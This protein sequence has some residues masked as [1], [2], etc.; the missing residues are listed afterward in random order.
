MSCCT[1][2]FGL[3]GA[4]RFP[5]ILILALCWAAAP[6]TSAGQQTSTLRQTPAA[7]QNGQAKLIGAYDPTQKLRLAIV[8][9]PPHLS[10]EEQFLRELQD[11]HS[12]N[13]HKFLS[14]QEWNQRFAPSPEDEQAVVTWA[15]SQGLTITQRFPN[16]LVV[17]VEAPVAVIEKTFNVGINS[18]QVGERTC[19]SNDRD[20]AIPT[21]L[22]AT[23]QAVL[24]LNSIEVMRSAMGRRPGI[25]EPAWPD[26]APGPAYE[27]GPLLQGD[28][29]HSRIETLNAGD[30]RFGFSNPYGPADI[31]ASTAYDYAALQN[32]GHC[33][34]P[35]ANPGGSP[36]QSSVAIA[37]WGDF[38]D[39]DFHGFISTFPYLAYN[40]QRYYVNGHAPCCDAET[41]L[42]VEWSTAMANSFAWGGTTATI[43]VYIGLNGTDSTIID[44]L[45]QALSDGHARVLN[46]SWGG[47]EI[48]EI[49]ATS[50]ISMHNIF[51]QY[52]GEGWALSAASG[53]GGATTDC[54]DHLSVNYPA[55]DPNVTA[56]G[57][58]TLTTSSSGFMSEV[59][60]MG[61]A[62]GCAQNDGGGGGGCSTQFAA[63]AYQGSTAC[64]AGKRSVPDVALNADWDNEPQYLFY[65]GQLYAAGG[66]SISAPEFSG[67]L[68]QENAYLL[69]LQNIVGNTCG[70]S[71]N[72]ACSPMGNP[73]PFIYGEGL[74]QPYAAHY[75]FY[76]VLSGCNSNDVTQRYH[77]TPFCA[78]PGLDQAT[79]WGSA[80]M[81][82]LAWTINTFLA[83]DF[84]PPVI[85]LSGPPVNQ[86]YNSNKLV[87]LTIADTTQNGHPPNGIAGYSALWDAD[88]GDDYS[89]PTPGTGN[90][91]YTGPLVANASSGSL[92]LASAGEGCHFANV[93]AWDN[94][95]QPSADV[96][97]GPLCYD[98][99]PPLTVIALAGQQ[100]NG[101]YQPQVQ[102]T[103]TASDDLS[104]VAATYYQIDSSGWQTYAGPFTYNGLGPHTI[105]YY[106]VDVAGNQEAPLY[107]NFVV[108]GTTTSVLTVAKNG[109]GSG[110]VVSADGFINCG[111]TCS[112]AYFDGWP[113]TLMPSPNPGSVYAGWSGC[114]GNP[115]YN[116]YAV[117]LSNRTVTVTFNRAVP[118]QFVPVTPCRVVD[119]RNPNGPFGGPTLQGGT[120]RDFAIPQGAC[121]IPANAAAYSFNV[122]VVPQGRL[123]FLTAWPTG[124][125]QPV[126]STINSDGRVKSVAAIV[127]SGTG[128]SVSVYASNTTDV[129]LDINGYFVAPSSSTLALYS[130]TPC[131]VVDT[132]GAN[133]PLGGPYLLARQQRSFPVLSSTC[134]IPSWA[135][136]Y[137]LNLA[138]I[139]HG[140][141]G[142][143]TA[144][145]AGQPQPVVATLNAPTGTIVA[146]AALIQ[147][148]T[149]GEI[150][151]YPTN[152][153]DLVID[154]NGY[155]GPSTA[156][157]SPLQLYAMIP[158]RALDTRQTTGPFS[159]TT[160]I[161]MI[162]SP[163]GV[164]SAASA[165]VM[166]ATAVPVARL[167]YLTLWPAGQPQPLAS[168]L[169]AADG[170]VT[171][172]LAIILGGT[173]QYAGSIDAYASGMTNLVLDISG[174]FGP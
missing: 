85:T 138:A 25:E 127:P 171:S 70:S 93:R 41:T 22:S 26:Y 52:A 1:C 105:A 33:C 16:R 174:Y 104:G 15:Q 69:Y 159:G 40:V 121:N 172:N 99:V 116:C 66:T 6:A 113:V 28:G 29:D 45:S 12:P 67:F 39:S 59:T 38:A 50:I 42:D 17:D 4:R 61:G 21:Q 154:I 20:P 111:S 153:T 76:D 65:Q 64:G 56:V 117:V 123:S 143:L 31:Y 97:Y 167:G 120:E 103:L 107:A 27:V 94:A 71:G 148:G 122:A 72:S 8:L 51:N 57:G 163:C 168:T 75:P 112:Y 73:N 165:Y 129:I 49:P 24:G 108:I 78:G 92:G 139:P 115:G 150:T 23:V 90:S 137:S 169:N 161:S 158:C 135:E 58:T 77:L 63:P 149:G 106:S 5:W 147:A 160:S 164:T 96:T 141:L 114:D 109:S 11:I 37:I 35:L 88:P 79:G 32:L 87:H 162:N 60:W 166:S 134:N 74:S 130:I 128:G 118:L 83:G 30:R 100:V 68:A 133:G 81:L 156:G 47:A 102:I 125:S 89:E 98:N 152:D 110:N 146:N 84:G 82:Q 136:G 53:D 145:P 62:Y 119:T 173:G 3:P 44:V 91:F 144:W 86:W 131:R 155:F 48:Y 19:F 95:G 157:P 18:Y 80:N 126:V 2:R 9:Q 140:R 142:Y 101:Y 151:V 7:V 55:S 124:Q 43:N 54:A 14:D 10:E 36:P 170:A 132:R 46:M 13:F 34:N